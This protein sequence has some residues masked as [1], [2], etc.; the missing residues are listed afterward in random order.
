[1]YWASS[2]SVPPDALLAAQLNNLVGI[3]F[4][5]GSYLFCF[6]PETKSKPSFMIL[7]YRAGISSGLSWASAGII[8]ASRSSGPLGRWVVIQ[9]GRI[10]I[11][12][13]RRDSRV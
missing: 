11:A 9:S 5:M 8:D 3:V 12:I 2:F 13:D 7:L 1:M 6:Q 10:S 4:D